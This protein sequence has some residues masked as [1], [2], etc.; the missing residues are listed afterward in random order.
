MSNYE[1][2]FVTINGYLLASGKMIFIQPISVITVSRPSFKWVV[3]RK[4]MKE[5]LR[6]LDKLLKQR[7]FPIRPD[8]T[9]EQLQ[10]SM[11]QVLQVS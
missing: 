7:S 8:R 2:L 6:V 9:S 3:F 11:G 4:Y 1:E 10:R 5:L